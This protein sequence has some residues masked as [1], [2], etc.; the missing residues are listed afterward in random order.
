MTE[1]LAQNL[2]NIRSGGVASGDLALLSLRITG[3]GRLIPP[4]ATHDFSR[5]G[6]RAGRMRGLKSGAGCTS[7]RASRR[8]TSPT[9]PLGGQGYARVHACV[10]AAKL[11]GWGGCPARGFSGVAA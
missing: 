1:R 9:E 10:G 3:A 4:G 11:R 2:L 7:S 5:I 6:P 8:S